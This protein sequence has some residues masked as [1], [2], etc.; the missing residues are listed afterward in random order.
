MMMWACTVMKKKSTVKELNVYLLLWSILLFDKV[1]V[2]IDNAIFCSILWILYLNFLKT[3]KA[4]CLKQIA[5]CNILYSGQTHEHCNSKLLHV[6]TVPYCIAYLIWQLN[7]VL[8]Y[9]LQFCCNLWWK[10]LCTETSQF[11]KN[12]KETLIFHVYNW[13]CSFL[14]LWPQLSFEWYL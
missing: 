4:S 1:H 10:V 2:L 13:S 7:W 3:G 5:L 11:L 9:F 6:H 14:V 8:P 12:Y